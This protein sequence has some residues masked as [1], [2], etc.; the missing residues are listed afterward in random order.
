MAHLQIAELTGLAKAHR[1]KVGHY[2]A[3]IS[4]SLGRLIFSLAYFVALAN[5]L[6]I[7][8]FGIFAAAS[9]AG[10]MLSRIIGFGFGSPL[11]RIAT[12][13]PHLIGTYTAGFL[14]MAAASIPL[15]LIAALA[16]YFIAFAGQVAFGTFL[17][18]VATEALVWRL[19]E[20]VITV[21]NGMQ[22]FGRGAAMTVMG[23]VLRALAA[24]AFAMLG[25]GMLSAWAWYYLAANAVSLAIAV[26]F[27]FPR[28]RLRF[29][30]G[31]YGRRMS[32]A[33]A[34]SGAEI[35]FYLQ[36]ELDKIVVLALGGAQAAGVYSIVMR[37]VDL[38]AIPVRTFNMMLVQKLMKAPEWLAG[39]ARRVQL[40][41]L[42]FGV[43]TAALL[44]GGGILLIKPDILGGNVAQVAPLVILALAV[45]GFR[46][47]IEYHAELLYARGQ[48]WLRTTNLGILAAVKA[49][50]LA[51]LLAQDF[52]PHDFILWLNA[53]FAVLFAVSLFLTHPA[54]RR[55]A[56]RI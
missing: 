43:S 9:A 54:L 35:L 1:D 42:I 44:C 39:I 18:V 8:D 16:A 41:A 5:T 52:G 12:V 28:V 29:R 46:N 2:A 50:L 23:T 32:D 31:L 6:T 34:V 27:Y 30:P 25:D 19:V 36:M 40:E 51:L 11:Y 20:I 13:K 10:V 47:L 26:I 21:N 49:A 48:T 38:T 33:L 17:V 22:R 53:A 3:A 14:V 55:P 37:L 24:V 7:A 4:G 45:P 56:T 15:F